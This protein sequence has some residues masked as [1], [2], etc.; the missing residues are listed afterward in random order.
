MTRTVE[1]DKLMKAFHMELAKLPDHRTGSN[2]Q[3]SIKEAAMGAFSVFFTQSP[4]FLAHQR[5]MAQTTGRSNASTLFKLEKIPCDNQIRS[6]LDPIPP[7]YL[8]PLY[9]KIVEILE[10]SG[11]LEG[12]RVFDNQLLVSLDGTGYFSSYKIHCANCQHRSSSDGSTLYYHTAI[13]PVMVAPKRSEVISLA[14]EFITPQDGHDKQ[15][16]ERMAAK[17]WVNQH[18]KLFKP[19]TVTL[20][21]DDLYCNQ[22]LCELILEKKLNF[23][24]VCKPDS[25]T[26]L[27]EWLA[28]LEASDDVDQVTVRRFNGC[29]TEIVTCRFVE[30]LPLRR[31]DDALKV[32]WCEI[33]VTHSKTGE[34]LYYNTFATN[35]QLTH[36]TVIPIASA[37]RARWKVENENNNTLKTKGYHLEHNFGHGKQY[38]ASFLLSLNLLAFLSH[39]LLELLDRKYALLRETIGPRKTFFDDIRT[40]TRYLCF[41]S[42][43]HLLDFMI[44]Q[45]E[46]EPLLDTS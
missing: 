41:D 8:H 40:L 20:L 28:M 14:P 38:L 15:D 7:A 24:F 46:L 11:E 5:A 16:C 37:G 4:S 27:Y 32:N 39:T 1:L 33:T 26:T 3:Y 12:F 2:S 18:A 21:G 45:L 23:I 34:Q 22:P 10:A 13:T 25:H 42:W 44:K 6:L 30:A 36:D 35:H 9:E 19:H 17:R 29:F 43:Q 31:G